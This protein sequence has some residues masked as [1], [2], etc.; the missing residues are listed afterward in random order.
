VLVGAARRENSVQK[1]VYKACEVSR[2]TAGMLCRPRR[3][4]ASNCVFGGFSGAVRRVDLTMSGVIH[5][6]Q[7]CE[8]LSA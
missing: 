2:R 6:T 8:Q 3:A 4:A 7:P 1:R 5:Q